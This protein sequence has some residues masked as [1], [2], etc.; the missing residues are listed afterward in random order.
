MKSIFRYISVL[1]VVSWSLISC[2]KEGIKVYDPDR[3]AIEFSGK[4]SAYSFKTTGRTVDTVSIPFNVE[5]RAVDYERMANFVVVGDSTTATNAE[6]KVLNAVVEPGKYKGALRV[7]VR[8]TVG[9]DFK[10]VRVYFQVGSN[11][12]FIPGV[13]DQQ[14]YIFTIT[15]K[16]VRPSGWTT[17]LERYYWGN[18]STAYYEFIIEATGETNF[19]WPDAI[20]DYNDGKAWSNG[21][22]DAFLELVK[23]KLKK[24]NAD[25]GELLLHD[26]GLAK[27]KE[28]VV[29]K[30]YSM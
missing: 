21:E 7:E 25:K 2:E 14:Y 1:M 6:Y 29:G 9:N 26:D 5:G 28:V 3:A 13:L 15:N 24:R 12:N 27:G 10:E 20:S 4:S 19:P 18:Y 16:L 22:K 8:N 17:W 30:Y 23:Y 11:D